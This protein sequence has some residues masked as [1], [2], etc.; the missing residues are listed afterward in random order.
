M[1]GVEQRQTLSQLE[2]LPVKEVLSVHMMGME[3]VP[4]C[5]A[6]AH[7]MFSDPSEANW[8]CHTGCK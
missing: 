2:P 3:L 8:W 5:S 1:S 6:S 4:M 7:V